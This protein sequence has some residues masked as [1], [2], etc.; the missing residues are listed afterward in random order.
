MPTAPTTR[1]TI[2]LQ[3]SDTQARAYGVITGVDKWLSPETSIGLSLGLGRMSWNVEDGNGTGEGRVFQLG[4]YGHHRSGPL[5]LYLSAG[6]AG[7]YQDLS[8]DRTY[9]TASLKGHLN[10]YNVGARI[11][12]DLLLPADRTIFMPY[13]AVQT[14]WLHTPAYTEGGPALLAMSFDE[15]DTIASRTELGLWVNQIFTLDSGKPFALF[16]RVGWAHNFNDSLNIDA[17]MISAGT[18]FELNDGWSVA[19]KLEGELGGSSQTYQA[20]GRIA[21]RW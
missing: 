1:P 11:E 12:A 20:S 16:G 9:S 17:A 18:A 13:G 4:A 10:G 8:T 3:T 5:Y 14:Q 6:V 19:G 21:Y 15:G 2:A 7:A